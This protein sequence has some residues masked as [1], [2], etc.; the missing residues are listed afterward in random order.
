MQQGQG[1]LPLGQVV[2]DVL[3]GLV[4][5]A[6]IVEQVIR[7]LEGNPEVHAVVVQRICFRRARVV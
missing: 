1:D 5:V 6:G 2:T 7:Q 4:G 3:A